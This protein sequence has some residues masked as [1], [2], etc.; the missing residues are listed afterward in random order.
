MT[1]KHIYDTPPAG[2]AADWTMPQ[3]WDAFSAEEHATWDKLLAQQSEAL[4][5][6]ASA[7]FLRGRD[8]L[9]LSRPGIP[10]YRE[11]NARLADS[12]GWEIVAVPG[13]IPNAPFFEH[14]AGRRFP[15]ANFLRAPGSLEYSE[16]PDMFHDLF[17]HV[18]TL[19]DPAFSDFLVAYGQAGL[20]AEKLGASDFLGRL[21]LYT[22]EF[23]L[24]VEE[25][26]LRAYGG[27]LLSSFAETVTALTD[28]RVR[29]MHLDIERVMRTPYNFDRFQDGYFVVESFEHLLHLTDSTDFASIYARIADLPPLDAGVPF[30]SDVLYTG[31]LSASHEGHR[32]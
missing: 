12:T 6:Y 23:G 31:P 20:R 28:P 17:G 29:R 30:G 3:N 24:V 13:W 19:T 27:G 16:E 11:L 9:K 5:R 1:A 4:E 7:S 25:G 15:V 22:V 18:P 14:L 32:G 21:W 8:V 26:A 2:V 10:D